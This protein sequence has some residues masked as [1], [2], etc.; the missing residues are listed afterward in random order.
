MSEGPT[1]RQLRYLL[2]S[3]ETGS[4]SAAAAVE[5]VAQPSLSEQIRR[6]ARNTVARCV[7]VQ[8]SRRPRPR[9]TGV[10]RDGSSSRAPVWP[11]RIVARA[12]INGS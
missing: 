7:G 1:L 5:C 2:R 9:V 6:L 11:G 8:L 12:I 4:F 10:A 3:V